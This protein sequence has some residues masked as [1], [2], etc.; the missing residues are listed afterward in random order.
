MLDELY[1]KLGHHSTNTPYKYIN[2]SIKP[3]ARQTPHCTADHLY[4]LNP[5]TMTHFRL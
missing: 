3:A 5:L 2:Y 1:I 4:P